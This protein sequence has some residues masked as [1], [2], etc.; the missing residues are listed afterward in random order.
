LRIMAI[1][2]RHEQRGEIDLM[3][4]ARGVPA[5]RAALATLVSR[6]GSGDYGSGSA[7]PP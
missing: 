3:N 1:G 6:S 5:V 4:G 2:I 7:P